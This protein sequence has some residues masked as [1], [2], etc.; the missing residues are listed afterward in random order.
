MRDFEEKN[1]IVRN[2]PKRTSLM[3][4]HHDL[5]DLKE[6]GALTFWDWFPSSFKILSSIFL[7]FTF[8]ILQKMVSPSISKAA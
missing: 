7:V 4:E 2:D 3:F 1:L 8:N 6:Q 5:I